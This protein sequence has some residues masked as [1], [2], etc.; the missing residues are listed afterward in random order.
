M[1]SLMRGKSS[2]D[3]LDQEGRQRGRDME[4]R[5]QLGEIG[6]EI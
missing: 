2:D 3:S 6:D 5:Q 4:G 1:P